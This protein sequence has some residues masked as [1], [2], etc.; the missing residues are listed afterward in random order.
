MDRNRGRF[1]ITHSELVEMFGEQDVYRTPESVLGE[2]IKHAK[3]RSLMSETGIPGQ[4]G[5]VLIV[6]ESAVTSE[7]KRMVDRYSYEL[8]GLP[9]NPLSLYW[10]ASAA[11]G[12]VCVD[13]VTGEVYF[14]K[15]D[16]VPPVICINSDLESF[17]RC[18]LVIEEAALRDEIPE[19]MSDIESISRDLVNDI[20]IFEEHVHSEP[21]GF[22]RQVIEFYLQ[23]L[24]E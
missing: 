20:S 2:K 11:G 13:G 19:S 15:S 8:P 6:S 4:L 9:R 1:M 22:W 16:Y 17:I 5:N 10:L 14:V 3:S 7:L 21:S 23:E 18:M 12:D 24:S